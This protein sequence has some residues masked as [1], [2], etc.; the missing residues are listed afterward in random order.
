MPDTGGSTHGCNIT[1]LT[2]QPR[3]IPV[4][5]TNV[6]VCA[7]VCGSRKSSSLR[8]LLVLKY[9]KKVSTRSAPECFHGSRPNFHLLYFYTTID[10]VLPV[11]TFAIHAVTSPFPIPRPYSIS[12]FLSIN[13]SPL[14]QFCLLAPSHLPMS[15][16]SPPLVPRYPVSRKG[17]FKVNGEVNRHR[18]LTLFL[19]LAPPVCRP[20]HNRWWM[21]VIIKHKR[22]EA[23]HVQVITSSIL[24]PGLSN[25]NNT[26]LICLR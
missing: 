19:K 4:A 17:K 7:C 12:T 15:P 16:V 20:L 23:E 14:S 26:Q 8:Q 2:F 22:R 1:G 24:S 21:E 11:G 10:R 25:K 18:L 9:F 3:D 6:R 13:S 5:S